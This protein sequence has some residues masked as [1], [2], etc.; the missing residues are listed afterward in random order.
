MLVLDLLLRKKIK[1]VVR[2]GIWLL[3]LVKLV[4]PPSLA[5]PTSLVA[6]IGERLPN[7]S[8]QIET[9]AP[10]PQIAPPVAQATEVP[11]TPER[12]LR[13]LRSVDKT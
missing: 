9:V 7:L 8:S 13:A 4:L 12:V 1:A 2:Y 11:M 3:I 6:W 10:A 5:S